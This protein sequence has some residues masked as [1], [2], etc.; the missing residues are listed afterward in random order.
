MAELLTPL[1]FEVGKIT[2]SEVSQ[3][4]QYETALGLWVEAAYNSL[5]LSTAVG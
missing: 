2:K 3:Q 5:E 1:E 4:Q